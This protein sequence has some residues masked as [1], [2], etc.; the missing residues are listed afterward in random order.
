M[1][2][3]LIRRTRELM[4]AAALASILSGLFSV[5]LINRALNSDAVRCAYAAWAFAG[6]ALV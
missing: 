5:L 1:L 6:V 3:Y 4:A 2:L